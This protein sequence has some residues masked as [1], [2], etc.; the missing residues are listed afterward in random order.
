MKKIVIAILLATGFSSC[1]DYLDIIPK[2]KLIPKSIQ[3]FEELSSN[4]SYSTTGYA[5]LERMS[6]GIYMPDANVNSAI[7]TSSSK[8]YIWAPEFYL[9]TENDNGWDPMYNNIYNA[10]IILENIPSLSLENKE[11]AAQIKAEAQCNRAFA[12]SNLIFLYA[13]TYN[14]Q[15]AAQDLGV[16]IISKADLEAT[17]SRNS[18]QEVYDFIIADLN[19][20]IPNLPE[21]AKNIYRNNKAT[22][23]AILAR[24]YLNMGNYPAA[25]AQAQEVLAYKSTLLDYNSFSF[26]NPEKPHAGINNKPIAVDDPE[27]IAYRGTSFGSALTNSC[28]APELLAIV[29]SKDLRYKFGWSNIEF[30]GTPNKE[31]YPLY[32]RSDLNFNIAVPEMMLIAAESYARLDQAA[33][34][35]DLLNKLRE[36]R[37]TAA[38][39]K[40]LTASTAQ[41]ALKLCIN[42]RRIEL[43]G[44][45]LRWLD[46]KRLDKDP[47]FAQDYVRANSTAKYTLEKGSLR[48][49]SQIPPKVKLL[50][51]GIIL[52][53]R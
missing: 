12:Y 30:N 48:F 8:T 14:A 29:D 1:Q 4:P 22:A 17:P 47:L 36:K 28:I 49:V 20:A 19:E 27:A 7:N 3:D 35:L 43:F 42:E 21:K 15:T 53:P 18:V 32:L 34:A 13:Q 5:L 24:V 38:D 6:D 37:F 26:K 50:N 46:M 44:K 2:G 33:N 45:G 10:N 23:K 51:T 16:P 11:K 52:N 40:K 25:L 39:Y 41:E 9:N 31:P